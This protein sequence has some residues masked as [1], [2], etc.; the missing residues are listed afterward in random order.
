MKKLS[1]NEQALLVMY[2]SERAGAFEDAR[3]V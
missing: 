1:N 3:Y 2:V